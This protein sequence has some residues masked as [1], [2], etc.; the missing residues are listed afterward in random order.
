MGKS[1]VCFDIEATGT[2]P[3]TD[4]IVEIS[5]FKA[6]TWNRSEGE[7]L[8]RRVNPGT[9]IP[10]EAAEVHGITDGHVADL[11]EFATHAKEIHDFVKGCDLC[12]FNLTMFDIPILW[13]ELYH[14]GIE[15]DLSDSLVFDAG[16][17]FKR[18]EP[19][20]LEAAVRF[21]LD[22]EH[23]GAHGAEA[24]AVATWDVFRRQLVEY[25]LRYKSREEVRDESNYE[26]TRVDLA[27]K[28]VIGKDGRPAYN[29]GKAKGTAVEDDPGMGRWMLDKDFTE[30]TKMVIRSILCPPA[31]ES[32]DELLF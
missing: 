20:T 6:E 15:W 27:G 3:A 30:N 5:L 26:E 13:E 8:T 4:R 11:P 25:G 12:G 2:D 10:P 22:R 7:L 23:E 18:R 1:I 24:D 17:L 21:Y 14:C 16:V 9:P 29:I 31:E 28:I 19:R 32:E